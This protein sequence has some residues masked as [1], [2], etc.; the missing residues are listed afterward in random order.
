MSE[1]IQTGRSQGRRASRQRN[2]AAPKSGGYGKK[3]VNQLIISLMLL[4]GVYLCQ[5]SGSSAANALNK[6]V[7]TAITYRVNTAKV[8]EF[9]SGIAR[10]SPIEKTTNQKEENADE[11][12]AENQ[13]QSAQPGAAENTETNSKEST[14]Q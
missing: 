14:S 7:K 3:F 11:N 2:A 10:F 9:V 12:T 6:Y 5:T 1:R 13:T 4:C 8:K